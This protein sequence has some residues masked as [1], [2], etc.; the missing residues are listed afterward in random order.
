[1]NK[2]LIVLIFICAF[3]GT[4]CTIV[5]KPSYIVD[6]APSF[7]SS[8]PTKYVS[9]QNSGFIGFLDNGNGIITSNAVTRYN[10]LVA[11]FDDAIKNETG[12]VIEKNSG[13]SPIGEDNM[14]YEI[15]AQHLYYFILMNQWSKQN[16]ED[17]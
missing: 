17:K 13:I 2:K 7:D 6:T 14:L 9:K 15:D 3:F 5:P 4:G 11:R 16:K 1:M 10:N 12:A 8:T